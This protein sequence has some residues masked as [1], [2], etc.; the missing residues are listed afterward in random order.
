MGDA[1]VYDLAAV[2]AERDAALAENA[3]LRAACAAKDAALQA[4]EADQVPN[5]MALEMRE[6]ALS[7][8]AGRGWVSTE[9]AVEAVP[10]YVF[11]TDYASVDGV[12]LPAA[13]ASGPVLIIP[14][15]EDKP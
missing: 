10:S 7:T 1:A 13:W 4:F 9:G 3:K 8:D 6:A 15:P 2:V 11:N 5:D 14:K 12:R